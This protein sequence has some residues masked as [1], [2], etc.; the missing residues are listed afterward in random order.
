MQ[1]I[2]TTGV[3]LLY[4][5]TWQCGAWAQYYDR[6]AAQQALFV[7]DI[8][9]PSPYHEHQQHFEHTSD[10]IP[11]QSAA[12]MDQTVQG[13]LEWLQGKY[14]QARKARQE[15]PAR[16]YLPSRLPPSTTQKPRPFQTNGGSNPTGYPYPESPNPTFNIPETQSPFSPSPNPTVTPYTRPTS[17]GTVAPYNPSSSSPTYNPP[18]GSSPGS[19][20]QP[21]APPSSPQSPFSE[22][23]PSQTPFISST[24]GSFPSTGGGFPSPGPGSTGPTGTS[25]PDRFN[26][27]DNNN[28]DDDAHPPHIHEINVQCAKDMMRIEIEFSRVFNGIIY[29]KGYYNS[30][31]CRYVS[32]N[33]GQTKYS[34]VVQLNSCGTQFVDQFSV[35]KQAY[36]ENVLVLQNEPGIQEVWDTIRSVRCLW[37]GN[38][39]KALSVALSV[40][41]LNQEIVT[42]SGDTAT[43]KLDIQMGRGPFAAAANGL[44]KIGETMTLVVTVEGDPGFNVLVRQCVARDSDPSSGNV[45]QLTDDRGCVLKPKLMGAFQTTRNPDNNAVI[46]YAFFQAFKFPDVMDLTI[47]C[48]VELCKTECAPCTDPNQKYEPGRRRRSADN[49]T[50]P[51]S[52]PVTVGRRMRVFLPEDLEDSRNAAMVINVGAP[53][54]DSVCLSSSVFLLSSTV[55]LS[56]L[57]ASC[58]C[59]AI[60]WL[61]IQHHSL[62]K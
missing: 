20:Q 25:F 55:L 60:L 9:A 11:R 36:L 30:P 50:E 1:T 37:E 38:L 24:G 33:S 18:T 13:I 41:M 44:V 40:G 58:V 2:C 15:A 31:E 56:I 59:S 35:G 22:T 39:N 48:N 51:L 26:P 17:T 8:D 32:P 29:S 47:E 4:M 10:R 7:R 3:L 28:I 45:V 21:Y 54:G 5:V 62:R 23:G 6:Q 53:A 49:A 42:F 19:S 12:S 43:A 46:A 57:A 14:S 61:R 52:E 27:G 34:L 16:Q